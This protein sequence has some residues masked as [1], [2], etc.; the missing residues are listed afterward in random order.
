[1]IDKNKVGIISVSA[2]LLEDFW[3]NNKWFVPLDLA[4]PN[5]HVKNN[6]T[7]YVCLCDSFK[8]LA[9][10]EVIPEYV[11]SFTRVDENTIKLG[12]EED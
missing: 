5:Q 10:Y 9:E 2:D 6:T 11:V 3:L 1:M 8:V 4:F 12:E 7:R